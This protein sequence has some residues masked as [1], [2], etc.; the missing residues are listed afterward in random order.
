M[1]AGAHHYL[2]KKEDSVDSSLE[3]DGIKYASRAQMLN[4]S[5]S[6]IFAHSADLTTTQAAMEIADSLKDEDVVSY[7]ED[8]IENHGHSEWSTSSTKERPVA[9]VYPRSTE[10]VVMIARICSEHNVPM[11]PFGAG[12]SVEGNFSS[13]YSGICIDFTYMDKIIAF[14]PEDLLFSLGSTELI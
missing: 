10:D 6:A 1:G 13:P 4:F 5:L 12:S 7:D 2:Q 9:V 3:H 14:H 11:V 8:V